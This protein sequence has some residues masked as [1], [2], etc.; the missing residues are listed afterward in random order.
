MGLQLNF[1][2]TLIT[3]MKQPLN[4]TA[5]SVY[6]MLLMHIKTI[7]TIGIT[8]QTITVHITGKLKILR[9]LRG[10]AGNNP[11]R[12]SREN[13]DGSLI[14]SRSRWFSWFPL[15]IN[16]WLQK[17]LDCYI[18]ACHVKREGSTERN[19]LQ[20]Y[21]F[22]REHEKKKNKT[23]MSTDNSGKAFSAKK[24][25]HC[26]WAFGFTGNVAFSAHSEFLDDTLTPG[27]NDN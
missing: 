12:S 13:T 18:N 23:A 4:K 10:K 24:C 7:T 19:M 2:S 11:N 17:K 9:S 25:S 6:L 22:L 1:L 15:H 14:E 20:F 21:A 3:I 8:Y 5:K 16:R 27:G 26:L